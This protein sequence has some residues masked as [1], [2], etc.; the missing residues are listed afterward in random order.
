MAMAPY[1]FAGV[2]V[3]PI[4]Y[5]GPGAFGS[6]WHTSV[7]ISNRSPSGVALLSLGPIQFSICDGTPDS[8]GSVYLF[9]NITGKL[10]SEAPH[11]VVLE[12]GESGYATVHIAA[13]PRDPDTEGTEIPV[14]RQADFVS[15]VKLVNVPTG[16]ASGH[17]V[18][19]LL[20]L[21]SLMPFASPPRPVPFRG[22]VIVTAYDVRNPS[23]AATQVE[24]TLTQNATGEPGYAEV[25]LSQFSSIAPFVNLDIDAKGQITPIVCSCAMNVWGFAS[26]TDNATNEVITVT[27]R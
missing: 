23:V 12:N 13:E 24:V 26:V 11:G 18:R 25:D 17:P 9:A 10:L 22:T 20:R 2:L 27:P 5:N 1:A 6:K 15:S 19:T 3:I 14:A 16:V 21:Y 8:C 7:T 4:N